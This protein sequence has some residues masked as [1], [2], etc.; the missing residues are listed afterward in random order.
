MKMKTF[1]RFAGVC[2]VCV[3]AAFAA[4]N[5]AGCEEATGVVGLTLTPSFVKVD[6]YNSSSNFVDFVVNTSVS[7]ELA[8][9]IAWTVSKPEMG[10]FD[11]IS[12][13]RARY[14]PRKVY[15]DT[16]VTATDQYGNQGYAQ[17]LQAADT[18]DDN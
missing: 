14:F 1:A 2:L 4:A 3:L 12:G 9:P 11:Q 13:Y 18:D 5:F 17:V 8:L 15:G 16:T 10:Y 6:P 7:N